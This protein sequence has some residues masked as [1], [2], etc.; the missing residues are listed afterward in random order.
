MKKVGII[1]Y[2]ETSGLYYLAD[3]LSKS[4]LSG[5]QVVFF[6]KI[7]ILKKNGVYVKDISIKIEDNRFVESISVD[8]YVNDIVKHCKEEN[9]SLL[10][11]LESLLSKEIVELAHCLDI[12]DIPMLEWVSKKDL[13]NNKYNIFKDI[14]C[15]SDICYEV[16]SKHYFCKRL[17]V[18]LERGLFESL[19]RDCRLFY[20]QCSTN[21]NFSHKNTLETLIAFY[22]FSKQFPD[23]KFVLTGYMTREEVAL[24]KKIKN[25]TFFDKILE[26]DEIYEYFKISG[27]FVA[28]S[29]KE[30]LGLGYIEAKEFG[31]K[32]ISTDY[33][34]MNEFSDYNCRPIIKPDS[35]L[36]PRAFVSSEEILNKMK[37]Y[38]MEHVCQK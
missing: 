20:H 35:S 30:G 3:R 25:I 38:Y 6:P 17:P 12:I 21:K 24:S 28:P 14:Y 2:A 11:S 31:A 13:K 26:V 22:K 9:I 10:Y 16:F 34:P 32:V 19:K 27:C 8:S 5:Q 7:R 29:I 18:N 4:L 23:A 33:S 15:V 36:Q 37:I 1:T